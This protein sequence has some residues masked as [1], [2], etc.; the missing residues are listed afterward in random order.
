[1]V[2]ARGEALMASAR[3]LGPEAPLVG[4]GVEKLQGVDLVSVVMGDG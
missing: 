2:Q 4:L 1:M 3:V